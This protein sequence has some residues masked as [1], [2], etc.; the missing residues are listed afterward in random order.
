MELSADAQ[1]KLYRKG[2]LLKDKK[3]LI[4]KLSPR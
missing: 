3:V 1:D 4:H 2:T